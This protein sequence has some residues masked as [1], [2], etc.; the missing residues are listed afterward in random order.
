[1]RP[2]KLG[3]GLDALLSSPKSERPDMQE[4]QEEQ[5]PANEYE[6]VVEIPISDIFPS[7]Y[8]PREGFDEVA[9][10]E[11]AASIKENG[12]LQP[13]IVRKQPEGYEIV[14]GERRW[15]AA[16][17]AGKTQ[18]PAIVRDV[19]DDK[20]LELALI[21]NIQRENLNP[22]EQA[23]A[24]KEL[25]TRVGLKH[26]EIAVKLGKDRSTITNFIRLLELPD[27]VKENIANGAL[28]MGHAKLLL[29][30]DDEDQQVKFAK[31][32]ITRNLTVRESERLLKQIA[33]GELNVPE[34]KKPAHILDIEDRL[35]RKLNTK[36][37]VREK[38]GKGRII[39]DFYSV[40]E[41]ERL[42]KIFEP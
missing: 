14:A 41:F 27:L 1:M 3:R 21:E 40:A 35:R 37:K 36:V 8:Q 30:L 5:R 23:R 26:D 6:S 39:I 17:K 4:S 16:Q 2:K 12:V 38:G 9:L 42:L 11:L 29:A 28:A 13:I 18:L 7:Q 22:I 25:L 34:N 15:R 10:G 32:M 19:E 33:D 31:K 20:V 24:F